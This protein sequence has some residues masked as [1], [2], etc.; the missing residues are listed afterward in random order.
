MKKLIAAVAATAVLA[1]SGYFG[2]QH[3]DEN[4]VLLNAEEMNQIANAFVMSRQQA[5]EHGLSQCNKRT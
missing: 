3:F 4:Y 5:F 2:K 1:A